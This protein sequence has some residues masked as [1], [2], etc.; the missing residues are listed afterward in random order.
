LR[1]EETT[2]ER[3]DARRITELALSAATVECTEVYVGTTAAATTRFSD[4][5]ITQNLSQT[6]RYIAIRSAIGNKVGVA[7]A[8]DLSD[9][10]IRQVVRRAEDI[11]RAAEPD[12]EYV[13][14]V[15]PQD[16][17]DIPA[18]A[19]ATA[20]C[21]PEQRAD[22]VAAVVATATAGGMRSS[23]SISTSADVSAIANSLGLFGF[24]RSS[25]FALNVTALTEDSSGWAESSGVDVSRLDATD[26]ARRACEKAAMSRNPIDVDPKPYVTILEPPALLE[27]LE[28]MMWDL[29]AKEADE[30][31]S[32]F[33]GKEGTVIGQPS[34]TIRSDPSH[35]ECP[36]S[37]WTNGGVITPKVTW[38]EQ[39]TLKTLSY[40][41]FW[42]Q[43]TGK[44]F[45]GSPSNI[46]MSGE[47]HDIED[48][49][50]SVDE[51]LLVTRFWY[52]RTVDPMALLHTGMTRDGLF[53]I[54]KG[55]IKCGV[56]NL[57]FNESQLRMLSQ[58]RMMGRATPTAMYSRGVVPP[59]L[60]DSFQ[61]T[62]GTKF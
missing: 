56:R 37:P 57:R 4:N 26:V 55:R 36:G 16:Y 12:T 21:D 24:H 61:F 35:P 46:L 19:E 42:A 48:L 34:V 10:S 31:R 18:F 53:W 8:N 9:E 62:S 44:P 3:D 41:R 59:V 47:D 7:T 38:V 23:G 2:V 14:P 11:A 28:F 40:S 25:R 39:G 5:S 6:D 29:D 30:G 58:V 27:F 43:K 13:P 60:L 51:G 45:T 32:G 22:A 17:P 20:V 15:G 52:I 50:A 54:E 1:T 33:A 49:I